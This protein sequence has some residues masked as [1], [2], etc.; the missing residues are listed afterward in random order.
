[1]DIKWVLLGCL[2][3]CVLTKFEEPGI[4]NSQRAWKVIRKGGGAGGGCR[5]TLQALRVW[6]YQLVI[7]IL[8]IFIQFFAIFIQF[9]ISKLNG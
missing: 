7:K 9:L 8:F 3:D 1:M 5:L 4:L 2:Y 6:S